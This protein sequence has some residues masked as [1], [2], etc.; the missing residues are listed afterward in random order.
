MVAGWDV[1][2]QE[3]PQKIKLLFDRKG[4]CLANAVVGHVA[5]EGR[6]DIRGIRPQ[7]RFR[8]V[9]T[10]AKIAPEQWN[11]K[12]DDREEAVIKWKDPYESP[13]VKGAEIRGGTTSLEKNI[14]N[15]KARKYE[16]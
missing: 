8:I 10:L 14:C 4:P 2:Q 7:P 9:N 12:I 13:T 11:N 6:I 3:R 15:K 1:K 16:E 5:D